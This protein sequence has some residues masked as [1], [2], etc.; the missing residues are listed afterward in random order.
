MNKV[1]DN[2]DVISQLPCL[3]F[4]EQADGNVIYHVERL[5]L[6]GLDL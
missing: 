6:T 5:D 1:K 4:I 3:Q 2:H